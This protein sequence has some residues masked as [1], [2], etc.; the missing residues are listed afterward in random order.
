MMQDYNNVMGFN[1]EISVYS[2]QPLVFTL[3]SD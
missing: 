3:R 2:R 1:P